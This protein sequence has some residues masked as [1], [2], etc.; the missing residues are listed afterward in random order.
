MLYSLDET[1][2]GVLVWLQGALRCFCM[3]SEVSFE[4]CKIDDCQMQSDMDSG[5]CSWAAPLA[6]SAPA[7]AAAAERGPKRHKDSADR[8]TAQ[9]SLSDL[10]L[11]D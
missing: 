5:S 1:K 2:T 9:Y 6:V 4:R 8:G 11:G 10:N 7:A 3:T